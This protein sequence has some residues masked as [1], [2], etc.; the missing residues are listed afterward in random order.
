MNNSGLLW[1]PKDKGQSRISDT[2]KSFRLNKLGE[3]QCHQQRELGK[4]L[5]EF[6]G[7]QETYGNRIR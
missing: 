7:P 5:V 1:V 2:T 3:E 6:Q 4:K